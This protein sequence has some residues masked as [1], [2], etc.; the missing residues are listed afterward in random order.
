MSSLESKASNAD[1]NLSEIDQKLYMSL[2][3]SLLYA[4]VMTRDDI[5]F[6]LAYLTISMKQA[7]HHH[8]V[9]AIRCL[10]YLLSTPFVGKILGGSNT[11]L[12][13]CAADASYATH[14]DRKSHFGITLHL[15][16][17]SGAFHS[18]SKKAKIMALSSTEAE[19]IAL[20]EGAK[21]ISWARQ[22]LADLGFPQNLPTIVFEDNKSTIH[23]VEQGTDRGKT[24]HMD[25]RFHYIRELVLNG[26]IQLKHQS[27]FLM[28][29]DIMT[30]AL[31]TEAFL[32]LRPLLMGAICAVGT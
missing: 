28:V 7:T 32:R 19:Y 22:F 11:V 27:T 16:P 13:W 8:M 24:K 1:D 23:M 31:P 21:L 30:K 6:S 12:L 9:T 18:V 14:P 17:T 20:F 26:S 29:A 3:G 25:V 15:G 10:S 4:S 2:V 5:R